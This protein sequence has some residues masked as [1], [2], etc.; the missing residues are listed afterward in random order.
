MGLVADIIAVRR[1]RKAVKL[2]S[3]FG[4]TEKMLETL[5]KM[6][7]SWAD[8][9][10]QEPIHEEKVITIGSGKESEKKNKDGKEQK[11]MTPVE[12]INSF[13]GEEEK[14][15]PNGQHSNE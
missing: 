7:K 6:I 4:L 10:T 3:Q 2:F 11:P 8:P 1:R 14:F 9:T 12:F 5:P 13:A 15:Y